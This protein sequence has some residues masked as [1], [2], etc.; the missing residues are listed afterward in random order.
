MTDKTYKVTV[1]SY[2]P[3]NSDKKHVT[4]L[5]RLKVLWGQDPKPIFD[6]F[7]N[8]GIVAVMVLSSVYIRDIQYPDSENFLKNVG[9]ITSTI[10]L[11]VSL[12]LIIMNTHYA[13]ISLNKLFLEEAEPSGKWKKFFSSILMWLYTCLLFALV[14][15]YSFNASKDKIEAFKTQKEK[16]EEIYLTPKAINL[17]IEENKLLK[18]KL[19]KKEHEII[20]FQKVT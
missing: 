19:L 18:E 15:M 17:L 13:Q 1:S 9:D 3:S 2:E 20:R 16:S 5:E 7:R 11:I 8:I 10:L 12:P 6:H 14:V 4:L